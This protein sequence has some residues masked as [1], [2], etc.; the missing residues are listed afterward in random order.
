[1]PVLDLFKFSMTF[2]AEENHSIN[3]ENFT[4]LTLQN[5]NGDISIEGVEGD[6]LTLH[7]VKI[8]KARSESAADEQMSR[9]QV[10]ISGFMSSI[11]DL[12]VSHG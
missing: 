12:K 2:T 9:V 8:V 3:T 10:V 7:A 4:H 1:M 11:L 5:A 6:T